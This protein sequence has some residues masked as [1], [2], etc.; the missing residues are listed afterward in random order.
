M[1][2]SIADR[3]ERLAG[4]RST[5]AIV[6]G[7]LLIATQGVRM[8]D[9]GGGPVS[10][11]IAG[12]SLILFFGWGSGLFRGTALRRFLNDEGSDASRRRAISIG[13]WNMLATALVCYGLTFVKDYGPRDAIQLILSV[14]ISSVLLSFGVSE[15]VGL[16]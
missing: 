7:T 14:G 1:Q 2:S 9:G 10:W 12:L 15:K 4:L 11:A 13:F 5:F 6:A 8:D 16:R 3:A